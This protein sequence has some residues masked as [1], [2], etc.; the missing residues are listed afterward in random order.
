MIVF[1]CWWCRGTGESGSLLLAQFGPSW[2]VEAMCVPFGR[3]TLCAVVF[4]CWEVDFSCLAF[5]FA[6]GALEFLVHFASDPKMLV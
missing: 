1:V 2:F 5:L 3:I 4:M 6:I